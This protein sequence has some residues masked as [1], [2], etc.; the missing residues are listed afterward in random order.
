MPDTT[1]ALLD[2]TYALATTHSVRFEP[3][4]L[5]AV[6][7]LIEQTIG[8]FA[9][10]AADQGIAEHPWANEDFRSFILGQIRRIAEVVRLRTGD[11]PAS[12]EA[13]RDAAL[14]VMQ[15]T[16]RVCRLAAEKGRLKFATAAVPEGYQGSVC[17][18]YL[19]AYGRGAAPDHV[20]A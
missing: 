17:T 11:A 3:P 2:V 7:E 9:R 10:Q 16:N 12:P 1:D 14:D 4:A 5:G 8:N 18:M 20:T 6:R 13:F 15:R 19:N